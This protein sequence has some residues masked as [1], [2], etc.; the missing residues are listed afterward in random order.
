MNKN[1]YV[2]TRLLS[3]TKKGKW[4]QWNRISREQAVKSFQ[5][6]FTGRGED[7]YFGNPFRMGQ[8]S[9]FKRRVLALRAR[10]SGAF[11]NPRHV[12]EM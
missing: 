4:N 5:K 8:D 11:A 9:E 12:T 10:G 1:E 6:Y 2:Q 7:G 3:A